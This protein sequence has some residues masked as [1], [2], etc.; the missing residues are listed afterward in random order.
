MNSPQNNVANVGN[1][2]VPVSEFVRRIRLHLEQG[3]PLGW[4]R[5]EISSL[6]RAASGHLYFTL[7]DS[8][9][10]LR[11]TMWRNRAQLLAF[12][13]REGMQVEVRAQAT[14]YEPRGDLQLSVDS[15]RQAGM[16]NLFEAFMRLKARLEEEGLFDAA[17][18]RPL[19]RLPRC[20]G[21]VTSPQAAAL[22]DV[23]TTLRRR[24]PGLQVVLYPTRVQGDGAAAEIAAAINVAGERRDLDHCEALIV[25]RG[26]GSLEDLWAFNEEAVVRAV[27]ACPLPVISGVGHETDVSLCDFAADLRAATPTAAAEQISSGIAT[28]RETLALTAQSLL[29]ASSQQ[30]QR[31]IQSVDLLDHRLLHPRTRI[32]A[33]QAQLTQFALRLLHN[34]AAHNNRLAQDITQLASRLQRR[35]PDT[36]ARQTRIQALARRMRHAHELQQQRKA[37]GVEQLA[38][39]ISHLDPR[40]TMQRGYAIVRNVDGAIVRDA[41]TLHPDDAVSLQ[42]CTSA[43]QAKITRVDRE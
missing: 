31:A 42:F 35:I 32:Q 18:K 19:P 41:T 20:I 27:H 24:A 21:L 16:G 36:Q 28:L 6:T 30:L 2:P 14:V 34:R 3:I 37:Q 25:C 10:Q 7:K 12:Q 43:A 9:A 29:R 33:S 8:D 1:Q 11:C 17:R 39:A 23:L 15:I 5:G 4:I 40:Q 22:H 26:G 38:A 13:L